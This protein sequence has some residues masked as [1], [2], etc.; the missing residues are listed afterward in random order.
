[1]TNRPK[2]HMPYDP[3][4]HRLWMPDVPGHQQKSQANHQTKE[5]L[6][7]QISRLRD[8]LGIKPSIAENIIPSGEKKG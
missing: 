6:E 4:P 1:M 3:H 7:A 2:G 8:E 5:A